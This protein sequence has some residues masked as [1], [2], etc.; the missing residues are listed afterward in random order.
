MGELNLYLEKKY[1]KS[2]LY[3]NLFFYIIDVK[4]QNIIVYTILYER[5][6]HIGLLYFHSNRIKLHLQFTDVKNMTEEYHYSTVLNYFYHL[7]SQNKCLYNV[8]MEV[9]CYE[10]KSITTITI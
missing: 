1:V 8:S 10:H 6:S 4:I 5:L 2:Y 7:D 3:Y 9:R